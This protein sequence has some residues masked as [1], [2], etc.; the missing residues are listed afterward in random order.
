MKTDAGDRIFNHIGHKW[1]TDYNSTSYI[2]TASD[3][4]LEEAR[5]AVND[6]KNYLHNLSKPPEKIFSHF[7]NS[8]KGWTD[9]DAT[10]RKRNEDTQEDEDVQ[11]YYDR[12][13]DCRNE[14][15]KN[16]PAYVMH[17]V[18]DDKEND[19]ASSMGFSTATKSVY[20]KRRGIL[21]RSNQGNS[22]DD[23]SL[24]STTTAFT[25]K[26]G[27]SARSVKFDL[28]KECDLIEKALKEKGVSIEQF[29][30]WRETNNIEFRLIL[31]LHSTTAHRVKGIRRVLRSWTGTAEADRPSSKT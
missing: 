21:K 22:D 8:Q 2:V 4:K 13:D 30:E 14:E 19:D 9:S 6:L 16:L 29:R 18:L 3:A 15:R 20:S 31:K 27:L 25:N 23:D 24:E 10:K 17:I 12:D 26:T 1:T 28:P 5:Q 11:T 7:A